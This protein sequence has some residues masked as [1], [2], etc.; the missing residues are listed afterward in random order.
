MNWSVLV[1]IPKASGGVRGIGLLEII[2]K[3]I[4]SIIDSRIK[5]KVR[6]HTALHGFR[7]GGEMSSATIE[8]KLRIQLAT[9]Y[10]H[11]RYAIFLDLS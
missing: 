6:F 3:T 7:P 8:A 11:P 4:S 1:A 2:W 5:A 9:I 10:Q